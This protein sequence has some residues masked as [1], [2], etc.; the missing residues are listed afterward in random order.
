MPDSFP[1]LTWGPPPFEERDLDALLCGE[2]TDTPV[3]LRQVA[4]ALAALRAAPTPTEL[5]GEAVARAEFRAIVL[6]E[7]ART[8]GGPY[9]LVLS[10][11]TLDGAHRPPPRHRRGLRLARGGPA[12]PQPSRPA[13]RRVRR[14]G[15]VLVGAVALVVIAAAVAL[16][17]SLSGPIQ[18]LGRSTADSRPTVAHSS[19]GSGSQ[20]VTGSGSTESATHRTAPAHSVRPTPPASHAPRR[21]AQSPA[22]R[23]C[24]EYYEYFKNSQHRGKLSSAENTLLQNLIKAAGG[25]SSVYAYCAPYIHSVFPN[26]LP[27][28]AF[29]QPPQQQ[30]TPTQ[31]GTA[32]PGNGQ[33]STGSAGA[34]QERKSGSTATP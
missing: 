14:P 25:Y 30:G 8:D 7:E 6:D 3:A 22:Q 24:T 23:P 2:T 16:T 31:P 34:G 10:A 29:P 33:P 12:R 18:R 21:P 17:A 5:S 19:S 15:G 26:G 27:P 32:S 28:W 13:G 4:D 1:P 20:A 11:L 9:A